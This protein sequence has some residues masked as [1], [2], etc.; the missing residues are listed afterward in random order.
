MVNK[1]LVLIEQKS[2]V[3]LALIIFLI[4]IVAYSF[5]G[6]RYINKHIVTGDEPHYLL[7][8]KSII[9]DGDLNLANNY[10]NKDYRSFYPGTL[11]DQHVSQAS[12]PGTSF[13]SHYPGLSVILTP[14]FFWSGKAGAIFFTNLLASFT[15]VL[16]F[17]IAN[18]V[19]DNKRYPFITSLTLA[20][21]LPFFIYAFQ[22][23]P[24]MAATF[25]TTLAAYMT[26]LTSPYFLLI[27][28][29]LAILPWLHFKYFL[30]TLAFFAF[31]FI[32]FK[33]K[34]KFAPF[35]RV[36]TPVFIS[37]LLLSLY[38]FY[39]CNSFLPNAPLII[40]AERI[41]KFYSIIPIGAL[42]LIFDN[43]FGLLMYSPYYLLALLGIVVAWKKKLLDL[44]L[45]FL[46]ILAAILP[47]I[48][49]SQWWG[50]WSPA[51]RYLVVALPFLTIFLAVALYYSRL[52]LT[53]LVYF[54]G[55]A[56]SLLLAARASLS[57]DLLYN[58]PKQK[59]GKL[60]SA[61]NLNDKWFPSL[62][63]PTTMD[64]AVLLVELVLVVALIWF[65]VKKSKIDKVNE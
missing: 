46:I 39:C 36:V 50:G 26:L 11:P 28:I 52:S 17:L 37:I 42:G 44:S 2:V 3:N 31:L 61:L 29:V 5:V 32:K 60:W 21:T 58:V 4:T 48:F 14:F 8:T 65:L 38:S 12:R 16:T 15:V 43:K 62:V 33:R 53:R 34:G 64:F 63:N 22:I 19:L 13:P 10:S 55:A 23:F 9:K 54:A 40:G 6:T 35:I 24:A 57:I 51:G 7:I 59:S 18:K 20:F 47:H 27:G 49:F 25:L 45:V 41:S 30:I 56:F 1:V